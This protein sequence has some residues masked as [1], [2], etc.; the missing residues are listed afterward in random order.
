MLRRPDGAAFPADIR[1]APL[2]RDDRLRGAVIT[3]DDVSERRALQNQFNHAQ[4]MEAVGRLAA[5]VAHDFNNL[6]TVIN[7]YADM[8]LRRRQAPALPPDVQSKL[9]NIQKAGNRAAALTR[10]LLAFSR[11]QVMDPKVLDMNA[12]LREMEPLLHRVLGEDLQLRMALAPNLAPVRADP[13]QIDQVLMNLAVNARDAMPHGGRLT[14]E[15][16]NVELDANY[17]TTHPE[18]TAGP[19]VMLAITDN[20]A[21][22]DQATL[23]RVFEPFFTTKPKGQGT[24]L[25]LSTVFG[26]VKQSGGSVAIYSELGHG[27]SVKVYLPAMAGAADADATAPG[28]EAV[29]ATRARVLVV[30]DETSVRELVREVLAEAGYQVF[31]AADPA[32]ALAL[33][34]READG[35]HLLITDVVMP[36]MNGRQLA[37]LLCSGRP[38]MAVLFISGYPQEAISHNGDLDE[39]L[40]FLQKPFT[41]EALL[42]RVLQVLRE[43]RAFGADRGAS[44]ERRRTERAA[45]AAPAD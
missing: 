41:P 42:R 7:G 21:G 25:G 33:S 22:M 43:P 13:S 18:A 30:E 45:G 19:H 31:A 1:G 37:G 2:R 12:V 44:L 34:A 23:T 14:I 4:K 28:G 15:S 20:G 35:F 36:G 38:G 40:A 3:F 39:G 27:T 10:Q 32:E 11:Q 5:G 9:V 24:G 6:L 17:V 29:T 26:I 8:L 16:A